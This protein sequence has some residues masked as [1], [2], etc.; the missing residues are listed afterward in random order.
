MEDI[1]FKIDVE[2]VPG[3][4]IG[5]Y[6]SRH[7]IAMRIAS[8]ATLTLSSLL[9]LISCHIPLH[10]VTLHHSALYFLAAVAPALLLCDAV[11]FHVVV[12][13]FALLLHGAWLFSFAV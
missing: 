5:C 2:E 9:A 1:D 3:I 13:L 12:A 7:K 8:H 11:S 10:C 4:T 6:G